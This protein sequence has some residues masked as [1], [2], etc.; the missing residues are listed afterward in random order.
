VLADNAALA[1]NGVEAIALDFEELPV[2]SDRSISH[3]REM[4]LFED[5]GTN[6]AMQFSAVRGDADAAFRDA[7]YIRRAHFTVHATR[8]YRWSRADCSPNGMPQQDV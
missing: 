7:E 6:L 8:H 1:E 2:V 5:A 3:R 4:L